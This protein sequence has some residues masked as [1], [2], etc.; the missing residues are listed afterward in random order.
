MKKVLAIVGIYVLIYLVC[1]ILFVGLFHTGLLASMDVLMYRG[2]VFIILTGMLAALFTFFVSKK[3]K[4]LGMD[5]KDVLLMFCGFC[6]VN[7]VLFTL[8]PVTVERSV[9][10]FML[11]YMQENE[12]EA[13]TQEE[14]S[15]IFI[16]R[17]VYDFGAFEKRFNE[18]IVSGNIEETEDGYVITD[19]GKMIVKMFRTVAEWFDTDRRIVYPMEGLTNE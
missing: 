9:S 18:Q 19:S 14:M 13:Y 2:I 16:D 15:E 7:M 11:S 17:Y 12:G 6:C 8:I 1:T 3:F 4:S 5:I 10:V